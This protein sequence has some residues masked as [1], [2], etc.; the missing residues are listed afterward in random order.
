MRETVDIIDR[1]REAALLEYF[2][3][4]LHALFF[5]GT[6]TVKLHRIH[7]DFFQPVAGVEGVKRVLEDHL[8]IAPELERILF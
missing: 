8:A 1:G 6:D 2:E 4:H 7:K 3:H 5:G